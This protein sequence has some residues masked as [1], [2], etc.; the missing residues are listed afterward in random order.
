MSCYWIIRSMKSLTFRCIPSS[1]HCSA[2]P[3]FNPESCVTAWDTSYW[4]HDERTDSVHE[5]QCFLWKTFTA[6]SAQSLAKID[7]I[8]WLCNYSVWYKLNYQGVL[9]D[10][11]HR[12]RRTRLYIQHIESSIS[13]KKCLAF[14]QQLTG[15]SNIL[16]D[17]IEM[18]QILHPGMHISETV[19]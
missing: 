14:Y 9:V 7:Q 15:C 6:Q 13:L 2:V 8:F 5:F 4:S 12:P 17:N 18:I 19:W 11:T 10:K 3:C 1:T 16:F